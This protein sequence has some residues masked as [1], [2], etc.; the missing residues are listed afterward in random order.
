MA[1]NKQRNGQI[2][3]NGEVIF[4]VLIVLLLIASFFAPDESLPSAPVV[5]KTELNSIVVTWSGPLIGCA[6]D[7]DGENEPISCFY[8]ISFIEEDVQETGK[9]IVHG[10]VVK[11]EPKSFFTHKIDN[12]D[13]NKRYL[14]R[15]R[16]SSSSARKKSEIKWGDFG[17]E[18]YPIRTL[19]EPKPVSS[20]KQS[21]Y[22]NSRRPG[23]GSGSGSRRSQQTQMQQYESNFLPDLG[24]KFKELF[25]NGVLL[26]FWLLFIIFLTFI[27]QQNV[28]SQE[29]NTFLDKIFA[30][31][32]HKWGI[33]IGV[34]SGILAIIGIPG[35]KALFTCAIAMLLFLNAIILSYLLWWQSA[36]FQ[37]SVLSNGQSFFAILCFF[38]FALVKVLGP[39][40]ESLSSTTK[41][42]GGRSNEKLLGFG[43]LY[44]AWVFMMVFALALVLLVQKLVYGNEPGIFVRA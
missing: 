14:F 8:E 7:G 39:V 4:L 26:S 43:I 18:S 6:D 5:S 29:I 31:P 44:T 42:F 30:I 10:D 38:S 1:E 16:H 12:L 24:R 2:L 41:F 20:I 17:P 27:L 25:K 11:Y 36:R 21:R 34:S 33:A 3:G 23:S 9:W 35:A 22:S 32:K 19:A 15:V 37:W 40:S 13:S 28:F